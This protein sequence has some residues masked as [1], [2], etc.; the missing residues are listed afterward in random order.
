MN[1]FL[2]ELIR[3]E[4][5]VRQFEREYYLNLKPE[6]LIKPE[7]PKPVFQFGLLPAPI[8]GGR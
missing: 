5:T 3:D 4:D 7:P 2:S 8:K 6:K 1:N